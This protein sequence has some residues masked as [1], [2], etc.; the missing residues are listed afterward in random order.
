PAR[1]AGKALLGVAPVPLAE[2]RQVVR[3]YSVGHVGFV[4]EFGSQVVVERRCVRRQNGRAGRIIET[5]IA[6]RT[7]AAEAAIE[8]AGNQF[9][10]EQQLFGERGNIDAQVV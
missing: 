2:A 7:W 4:I 1:R 9:L 5:L 3:E 8:A 6:A 10:I